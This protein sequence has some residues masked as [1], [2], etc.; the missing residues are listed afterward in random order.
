[1][2]AAPAE[3]AGTP[4]SGIGSIG[5]F[6][7]RNWKRIVVGTA[8]L[9]LTLF[10]LLPFLMV[11]KISL[12]DPIIASPPYTPFFGAGGKLQ[13]TLDNFRYV[14]GDGLYAYTY[15]NSLKLA[16]TSTILCLLIGYPMAYGI[17]RAKGHKRVI[18]LFFVVLPFWT[19]FLLRVYSWM[20]LLGNHG[21]INGLLMHFG[22]VDHPIKLLYTDFAVYLG[23]TYSYLPFIILP[24]YA[25]IERLGDTLN[26]AAADLGAGP[27]RTFID[28]TLPMTAPGI[29]AGSLLVFIPAMG[30]YVIPTLLGGPD[31]LMIGRVL[32]DEF[33]FNRD[34]PAASAVAVILL[35][36]L[37][38]PIVWFQH[39]N[40]KSQEADQ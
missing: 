37:I 24:L 23:I 17:A 2:S 38:A 33:F 22:L 6:L 14:L 39:L 20:G 32:Y 30:E 34:W 40:G 18:L 4:R 16:T 25:S 11:M 3:M 10:F 9:W 28:I 21:L 19:S 36:M 29:L 8:L 27:V 26:E 7:D 31:S 5:D 1:M 35:L 15:L 12:A 13:A